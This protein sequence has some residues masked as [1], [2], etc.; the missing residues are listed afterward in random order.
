MIGMA[1]TRRRVLAVPLAL[2]AAVLTV[3]ALSGCGSGGGA[4]GSERPGYGASGGGEAAAAPDEAPRPDPVPPPSAAECERLAAELALETK[5]GRRNARLI[6]GGQVAADPICHDLTGDER[7]DVAFLISG[8]GSGGAFDWA[9]FAHGT[10]AAI[11][12]PSVQRFDEI[13]VENSGGHTRLR[14]SGRLLVVINPVFLPGD[15]NCCPTGGET[16]RRYRVEEDRV[17]LVNGA[18]EG[19]ESATCE[20]VVFT[21]NSD[22]TT[23]E[24]EVSGI[25]CEEARSLLTRSNGGALPGHDCHSELREEGLAHTHFRCERGQVTIEWD[26]F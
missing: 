20:P 9:V 15:A 23:S 17:V 18:N 6:P 26:R 7:F 21:P 14:R 3:A 22:D 24:V 19:G 2:V 25:S 4:S 1:R 11:D 12:G 13:A 5:L 16:R 8:G 10:E